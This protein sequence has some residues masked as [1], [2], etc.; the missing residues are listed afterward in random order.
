M[1]ITM[2]YFFDPNYGDPKVVAYSYDARG[3]YQGERVFIQELEVDIPDC[4]MPTQENITKELVKNLEAKK[5]EIQAEA[6][7]RIKAI[8][9]KIQSLLAITCEG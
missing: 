8:D 9:E 7:M 4:D 6:H 3:N 1:K 5:L 2:Y